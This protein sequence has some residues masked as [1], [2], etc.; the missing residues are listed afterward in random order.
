M[1]WFPYMDS[2]CGLDSLGFARIQSDSLG[3]AWI[4]LDSLG[5]VRIQSDSMV[6][7]FS[8]VEFEYVVENFQYNLAIKTVKIML[9]HSLT[10]F[11]NIFSTCSF[12]Y[13]STNKTANENNQ[14]H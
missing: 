4:Q 5:F 12:R 7:S 11:L 9:I 10:N 6:L 13:P 3:F 2:D 1:V 14:Q 8:N